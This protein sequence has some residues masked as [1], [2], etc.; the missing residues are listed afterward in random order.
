MKRIYLSKFN[1][2]NIDVLTA[3]VMVLEGN[4]NTV[5][6]Y[7]P[8]GTYDPSL[9]PSCNSF[10][11]IIPEPVDGKFLVG[12]GQFSEINK[13]NS[14][15]MPA[16]VYRNKQFYPIALVKE[17]DTKEWKTRY[18]EVLLGAEDIPPFI[19]RQSTEV[20]ENEVSDPAL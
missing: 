16:Y 18:G 14:I 7:I 5:E 10:V 17:F 1:S 8:G 6:Q 13:A 4:N 11:A 3:A 9:L 2:I 19:K 20:E 15:D 12:K